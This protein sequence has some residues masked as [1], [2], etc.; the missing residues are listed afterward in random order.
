VRFKE[1]CFLRSPDWQ[2]LLSQSPV[3]PYQTLEPRTLSLRSR[4]CGTLVNLP[5]LIIYHLGSGENQ[6]CQ[7]TR[8]QRSDL[9]I[10]KAS[11]IHNDVKKWIAAEADPLFL[12]YASSNQATQGH[13]MYPDIIAG[14]L[15][16]V[17]H[18]AL[19]TIDKILR[20]LWETRLPSS[21][22]DGHERPLLDD[23]E[24]IERWHQRATTAFKFV[25]NESVLAAKP[26]DFGLR[27]IQPR[28]SSCAIP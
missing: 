14:V 28:E 22:M 24:T 12:S 6:T 3:W 18:T 5:S 11:T 1:H 2:A 16:C 9:L 21:I 7:T 15:D 25:Q 17:A 4:L 27:Q 8:D 20:S 26:L 13:M 10:H 23:P 19:A